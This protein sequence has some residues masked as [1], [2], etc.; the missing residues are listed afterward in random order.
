MNRLREA[1]ALRPVA[2]WQLGAAYRLAGLP[3]AADDLVRD[4]TTM[5]THSGRH[6][7]T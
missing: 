4:V 2:R 1:R 7:P 3:D 5:V 6:D